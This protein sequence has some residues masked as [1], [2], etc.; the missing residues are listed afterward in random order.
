MDRGGLTT[1]RGCLPHSTGHICTNLMLKTFRHRYCGP[2]TARVDRVLA[3]TFYGHGGGHV[4][5]TFIKYIDE[6]EYTGG[7]EISKNNG[8]G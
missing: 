1:F 5:P 6:M 8:S 2:W 7:T 4:F 3:V